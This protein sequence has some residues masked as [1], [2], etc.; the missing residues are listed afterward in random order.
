MKIGTKKSKPTPKQIEKYIE[1]WVEKNIPWTIEGNVLFAKK[2]FQSLAGFIS[3]K[4]GG[5]E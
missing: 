1:R 4:I 2:D 5:K 3:E